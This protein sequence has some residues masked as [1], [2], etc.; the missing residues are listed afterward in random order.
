MKYTYKI[1]Y[2]DIVDEMLYNELLS[3]PDPVEHTPTT[4]KHKYGE[5]DKKM[6]RGYFDI[7]I[8]SRRLPLMSECSF[9]ERAR[10]VSAPAVVSE[11][12][13]PD[14]SSAL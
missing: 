1:Q 14:P 8:S 10:C 6:V 4:K 3:P 7:D 11:E 5:D 13:S 12:K 2:L 9:L